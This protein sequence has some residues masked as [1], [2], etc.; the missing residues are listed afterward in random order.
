MIRKFVLL[1]FTLGSSL[2]FLIQLVSLQIFNQNYSEL[3]LNNAL[4]KRPVYPTRGLIYDRNG[5]LLVA[6]QPVYDLMV[7]PENTISFDTLELISF[8]E[9]SKEELIGSLYKAR[10]FSSKRPS[11]VFRQISK[12]KQALF[13]EK[14]W[15]YTGFYFQKKTIRD[16]SFPIAS[17][18][19]GYTSEINPTELKNKTDY[20]LGEMIGRQG[21][22]KAYED[23]L[24]GRKGFQFF[25][26]DRFNR[27]IGSY[28]EGSFDTAPEAANNLTLTIDSELQSYGAS[29][30]Q[31][32]RGGI[33][34]IEPSS[35]E[36]LA[37]V[38][39]PSYDPNLLLGS[40]RS[41]NFRALANDTLAK[42]LF[43]RGL[44][45]EYS[46]GSPFKTL[47]ALIALQEN[48]ISPSTQF[49]CNQGHFY[50]REAFMKCHCPIG[51]S[52]S[53]LKG[54]YNSC[55][56]FFAKTYRRIIEKDSTAAAGLDRWRTHLE[57]F[58]LGN[59]LGYDLP[60][61]K[62]GF[63]P[64][65]SYYDRWYSKGNWGPTTVISNAIGQGEILTT[66][67]QMANFT[68]AIANRGFYVKPH[69][70]TPK[71]QAIKDSLYIKNYTLIEARH[72]ETVIEGMHQ[73]VERGTARIAKIPGIEVCGKTG[74]A[75]NFIRLNGEKTQLTDHSIFVAFA[76]KENPKIALA[77]FVENGYWGGRWAAPIASL[78][79]EKY[80]KGKV[81]RTWLEN[82]MLN[83]SLQNEYL[84]P[85]SGKPFEINE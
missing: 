16:Y 73:V 79:I 52:N 25:Q 3:S 74:T 85:L 56:S 6:N 62:R 9:I 47:N 84:K 1:S 69:F 75:E 76:P 41:E 18:I 58:G 61:G 36:V 72:F 12:E 2:L 40:G 65:S 66:P 7:I 53:L 51:T 35:G 28:E 44:Q 10:R 78:M 27:I 49:S 37:L 81:K 24:R 4:E 77:V 30:M 22:E 55:N 34:A 83:G 26:K 43:D 13:K 82:R 5:T 45:A 39:A 21:I 48:V 23:V 11:V 64:S 29:L 67:I 80:L 46:P 54:I 38:T 15:K 19:L 70:T 63:I 50:A 31:N 57:K 68:A 59:Y 8:L 14:I 33:V 71:D 20:D 42:P 17:N 60:I 32:K